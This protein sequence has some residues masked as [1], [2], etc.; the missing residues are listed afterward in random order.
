MSGCPQGARWRYH[1]DPR[2]QPSQGDYTNVSGEL[3]QA[4]VK[5]ELL[6]G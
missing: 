4:V 1:R 3:E 5:D 2:H 6:L